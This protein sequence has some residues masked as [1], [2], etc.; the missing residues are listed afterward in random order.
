MRFQIFL[1][2]PGRAVDT[3]QHFVFTVAA[4]IGAG[5][6]HQFERLA[7]VLCRRK[8]RPLTE[9][10]PL[11]MVIDADFLSF[12]Q[13]FDQLGFILFA[14]PLEMRHGG[15]AVHHFHARRQIRIHQLAMRFSILA[16]SSEEK[17]SSRAKS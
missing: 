6:F 1:A 17:G 16:K 12:G 8:V 2:R 7:N 10:M 13:I 15:V 4:P 14:K 11:A 3:L 5:E 9:I